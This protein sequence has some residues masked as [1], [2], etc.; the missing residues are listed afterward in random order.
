MDEISARI[1]TGNKSDTAAFNILKG[2]IQLARGNTAEALDLI[3]TGVK[4]RHDSF[5]LES[6]ANYYYRTGELDMAITKYKEIIAIR[7]SLGWEA[8]EYWIKAHY[9]LG[10]NI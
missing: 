5:T 6:L 2:E 4:L 7:G 1:S 3:E 8:Q 10:E 9:N